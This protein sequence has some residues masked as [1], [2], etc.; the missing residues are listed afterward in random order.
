MN[1]DKSYDSG[2]E[3]NPVVMR[4]LRLNRLDIKSQFSRSDSMLSQSSNGSS[5]VRTKKKLPNFLRLRALAFK[6]PHKNDSFYSEAPSPAAQIDK[7]EGASCYDR[8]KRAH[9]LLY[10]MMEEPSSSIL[11]RLIFLFIIISV[12]FTTINTII[13]SA[14][15]GPPHE[16]LIIIEN[17]ISIGF[18]AEYIL[19]MISSPAFGER[20]WKFFIKPISIVDL[21]SA[22]PFALSLATRYF[23]LEL[24]YLINTLRIIRIFKIARYVTGTGTFINGLRRSLSSLGSLILMV[25]VLDVIFATAFYY[26]ETGSF[27]DEPNINPERGIH[28]FTDAMWVVLVSLSSVGY[29][30]VYPQTTLGRVIACMFAV[31]GMLSFSIPVAVLGNNFHD[32]YKQMMEKNKIHNLKEQTLQSKAD[33]SERKK[34]MIFMTERVQAIDINNE[35]IMELLSNSKVLYGSVSRDLRHLYRSIYAE[36][37]ELLRKETLERS[38]TF[39][40]KMETKIDTKIKI[41][42]KLMKAKK[43]IKIA[44]LFKVPADQRASST[45][46][47]E[48]LDDL[49]VPDDEMMSPRIPRSRKSLH[50]LSIDKRT[51]D[52]I[53]E[54]NASY[55]VCSDDDDYSSSIPVATFTNRLAVNDSYANDLK[56]YTKREPITQRRE[57]V[58]GCRPKSKFRIKSN[59]LDHENKFIRYY[60][61]KLD[62]LSNS[63]LQDLLLSSEEYQDGS[64]DDRDSE[65]FSSHRVDESLGMSKGP[66]KGSLR[67]NQSKDWK[68]NYNSSRSEFPTKKK[69]KIIDVKKKK[70][71]RFKN[72]EQQMWEL[73]DRVI[74][75]LEQK[76]RLGM[77]RKSNDVSLEFG[78][79]ISFGSSQ[80]YYKADNGS[81]SKPKS[82][83]DDNLTKKYVFVKKPVDKEL[84]D[85]EIPSMIVEHD[86]EDGTNGSFTNI[87]R[88][89]RLS[90]GKGTNRDQ[91]PRAENWA[92]STDRNL[93]KLMLVDD[94]G[95]ESK[96]A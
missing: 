56:Q 48:S 30:D 4:N 75:D 67:S 45:F 12:L 92:N 34:E 62:F 2:L 85:E 55:Y 65:E 68:K 1:L 60:N 51:R 9:K 36:E 53:E 24:D 15:S 88:V 6:A 19:R 27:F 80:S 94:G 52:G 82:Y 39:Q 59:S 22:V 8:L 95:N 25:S 69:V 14:L 64:E 21:L 77:L 26:A 61:E 20:F 54:L 58:R 28:T 3:M 40:T 38:G 66:L 7:I 79:A 73:A 86:G 96:R 93:L 81:V 87:S 57:P 18:L 35:K 23:D 33:L 44:N 16:V 91:T 47:D 84:V 49:K 78:S 10:L 90:I 29:G 32:A 76:G 72:V 43:K 11:A 46:K 83:L 42:E 17:V 41:I 71:K 70:K 89:K 74:E 50:R 13:Q 37:E 5:S 31:T 63:M